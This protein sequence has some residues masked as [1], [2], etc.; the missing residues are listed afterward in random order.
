MNRTTVCI[1]AAMVSSLFV[2]SAAGISYGQQT[3]SPPDLDAQASRFLNNTKGSWSD[4]N[5][6]Y[7]DGKILH[8]LVLKAILSEFWR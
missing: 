4:L 8:D 3:S 2:L 6:P 1:V 7:V 5:V